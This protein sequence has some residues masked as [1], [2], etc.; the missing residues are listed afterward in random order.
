VTDPNDD[1]PSPHGHAGGVDTAARR[2]AAVVQHEMRRRHVPGLSVAVTR[3]DRLLHA[4]GYGSADLATH[5]TATP[6]TAYLWFSMSKIA[7]A[8]MAMAAAEAGQ[9]D[10]D[11]PVR[12]YVPGYPAGPVPIQPTVRQ[13][14]NHTAGTANPLPIRWV[15]RAGSPPPDPQEF[16]DR[17]LA[18]HG[19]PKYPIGGPA[20]YSNLGYLLLAEAIAVAT[21]QRFTDNVTDVLLR[22]IGMIC[23]G[24]T[25]PSTAS[26]ATG[27]L[28]SPRLVTPTLKAVLP[29]GIV[30]QRLGRY[31]ALRPFLVNGPGYGG[32]VG[33]V[34][35]AARLAA[36]HL[37]N[38]SLHEQR[39]LSNAAAQ[40]MRSITTEGHPFDLG[41]GWFRKTDQ[42]NTRPRFVEHYGS[43]GGC[44]NVIRIYPDHDLGVVVMANTTHPYNYDAICAAAAEIDWT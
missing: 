34:T 43:G 32:L 25:W 12:E 2:M 26:V 9:L 11:A 38:G 22:P 33:D 14:L 20:R 35:D 5:R 21:G 6:R 36:L 24:Y 37:G 16:L 41:L 18:R 31:Q 17:I 4:A 3:H 42:R 7:T 1:V 10:L 23:T 8:T 44:Y 19:R 13:L 30:G 28:R 27:Y 40:R 29:G 15:R 39:V